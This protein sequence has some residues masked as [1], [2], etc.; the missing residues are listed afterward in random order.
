MRTFLFLL[1]HI[2]KKVAFKI[3]DNFYQFYNIEYLRWK[4]AKVG[5]N[6]RINCKIS[7]SLPR[8]VNL[9]IGDN[10]ICR[11]GFQRHILGEEVS[12][13]NVYNFSG[14]VKIGHNTGMSATNIN[15]S[16]SISIG[17]HV[18]IGAGCLITDSD[19]HSIDWKVRC[20]LGD[21]DKKTAP[22]VI[23]DY[24]FIGARSIILKG[25][26][27]GEKSIVAAGSVVVKNIPSGEMWGGNPAKFIKKIGD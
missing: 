21:T 16:E 2:F 23:E 5:N 24:V 26:T 20:L 13:I 15:C 22:I 17:N 6:C 7:F 4:G 1:I 27:I 10:F 19:H 9:E 25:V 11:S 14:G 8:G 3:S 18:M 12:S